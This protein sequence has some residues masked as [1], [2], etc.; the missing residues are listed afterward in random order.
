M[1]SI[2]IILR[3]ILKLHN[4]WFFLLFRHNEFNLYHIPICSYYSNNIVNT[5]FS[6]YV[7]VQYSELKKIL[8]GEFK[9]KYHNYYGDIVIDT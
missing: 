4:N 3:L 2:L 6:K 5:K 7:G 1:Y 8:S 9:N